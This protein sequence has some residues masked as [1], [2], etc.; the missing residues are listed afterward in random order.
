MSSFMQNQTV[1]NK[2][3]LFFTLGIICII[4]SFI[5]Y[6]VGKDSSHL[7]ELK[8]FYWI[9]LPLAAIFLLAATMA[10]KKV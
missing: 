5:M 1:M 10:K 2:K 4:A 8:D 7:S 9:P 6:M 3:N